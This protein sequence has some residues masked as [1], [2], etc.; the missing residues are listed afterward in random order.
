MGGDNSVFRISGLFRLG[1]LEDFSGFPKNFSFVNS[2]CEPKLFE[3]FENWP[4]HGPVICEDMSKV[5]LKFHPCPGL[6]FFINFW[7][8]VLQGLF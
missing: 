8:S 5:I 1:W 3:F 7:S 4:L 2:F 6:D